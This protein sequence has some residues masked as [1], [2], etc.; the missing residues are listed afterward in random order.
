M[1]KPDPTFW[2]PLVLLWRWRSLASV[3]MECSDGAAAVWGSLAAGATYGLLLDMF[4]ARA[5]VGT[6]GPST[7]AGT[8]FS[9]P[10]LA[11]VGMIA[12]LWYAIVSTWLGYPRADYP[13]GP[14]GRIRALS[15]MPV[16][17][18]VVAWTAVELIL[19]TGQSGSVFLNGALGFLRFCGVPLVFLFA[20]FWIAQRA[21]RRLPETPEGRPCPFCGQ[22]LAKVPDDAPCP[23]CGHWRFCRS[24]GYP[25]AG[26]PNGSRCPECG[27]LHE[28]QAG[29]NTPPRAGDVPLEATGVSD[30]WSEQAD[31]T[32]GQNDRS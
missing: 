4:V 28:V 26:L 1:G 27:W 15:A 3:A 7:L 25:L 31:K 30:K 29:V 22:D 11:L 12:A 23:K 6:T 13:K 9:S 5:V 19:A 2:K 18:P 8:M 32:D 17:F 10:F 24:C 16:V 21:E 20:P 14:I